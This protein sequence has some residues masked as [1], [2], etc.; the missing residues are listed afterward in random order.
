MGPLR[1]AHQSLLLCAEPERLVRFHA[2][3]PSWPTLQMTSPK[4]SSFDLSWVQ[5]VVIPL[6]TTTLTFA[7]AAWQLHL[8]NER[9]DHARFVDSAQA[10]AQ[11]TSVLLDDGYNALST[12]LD[13]AGQNGWAQ[14]S[15]GA[16]KDY[17]QF[18]RR[19]RQQLISEHFKLSRYFGKDLAD[20]LV[21]IDE[22]D[23]RP[24]DNLSSPNPCTPAGGKDAFDV[25]KLADQTECVT[26]MISFKRDDLAS[27]KADKKMDDL[28]EAIKG[29][30]E[31]QDFARKLLGQYDKL[32]VGYLRQLDGRLTQMGQPQ[33]K[34]TGRA[35]E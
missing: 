25:A 29:Q 23:V 4:S 34:F 16:W 27:A 21:H 32:T 13:A 11:E 12:L 15:E 20:Q 31:A 9:A 35:A 7:G 2:G 1:Q 22:I 10:T 30:R 33:V 18:H 19:W 5:I 28:F 24:V 3:S 17:R 26:T 14:F 8:T 6:L